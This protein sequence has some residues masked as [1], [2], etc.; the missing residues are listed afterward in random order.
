[1]TYVFNVEAIKTLNKE[2][3]L[4][5]TRLLKMIDLDVR[6]YNYSISENNGN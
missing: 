3:V 2:E 4:L 6:C 5:V 1:L